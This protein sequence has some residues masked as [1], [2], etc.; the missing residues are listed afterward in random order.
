[1]PLSVPKLHS[2]LC[3][4]NRKK[5]IIV[6]HIL[7]LS[8]QNYI[9]EKF[10]ILAFHPAKRRKVEQTTIISGG[11]YAGQKCIILKHL[12]R[13]VR[14][15]LLDSGRVTCI[16]RGSLG[17]DEEKTVWHFQ[18]RRSPRIQAMNMMEGSTCRKSQS[19]VAGNL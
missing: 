2:L 6:R 9:D 14:V 12:A 1:M 16:S 17:L 10:V 7:D 5:S 15:Q 8:P 11:K 18:P 19:V 4:A 13:R 3:A